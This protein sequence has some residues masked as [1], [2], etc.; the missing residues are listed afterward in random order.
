VGIHQ[1]VEHKVHRGMLRGEFLDPAGGGMDAHQQLLEVE[2]LACRHH[3][4]AVE[5]EPRGSH[6]GE[7]LHHLREVPGQR[8]AGLRLQLDGR[9]VAK[10][11][12]AESVPFRLVLPLGALRDLACRQRFHRK[13]G[14][15][16]RQ[17]HR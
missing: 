10:R 3:D 9:P 17:A 12:A 1:Q 4:F 11:E 8:L 16:E 6:A 15:G 13:E 14:R 2:L 7:S 5:H